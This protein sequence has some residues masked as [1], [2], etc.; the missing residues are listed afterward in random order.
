[1]ADQHEQTTAH[2][3]DARVAYL[4]GWTLTGAPLTDR[5]GPGCDVAVQLACEHAHD[6][7]I[8]EATL[9]LGSLE[10]TWA[11]V[12]DRRQQ[13]YD[14]HLPVVVDAWRTLMANLDVEPA[15]RSVMRRAGAV[16]HHPAA[17]AVVEAHDAEKDERRANAIAAMLDL[18]QTAFDG[19][20]GDVTALRTALAE[21]LRLADAEG[22]AGAIAIASEQIGI[23]AI[24]WGIAFKDGID[25][26]GQLE[27]YWGLA[28]D[29]ISKIVG[30]S[31]NDLGRALAGMVEDGE[32]IDVILQ[33]VSDI[34][35][36]T[37][38][39]AVR[40]LVD[41]AMSQSYSRGA[42]ALYTRQGA[43]T[44]DF[45]TAGDQRVCPVCTRIENDGPYPLLES[46]VPAMHP[47]CRCTLSPHD[48]LEA[49]GLSRY[50][51]DLGGE[52]TT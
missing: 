27:N 13:L 25:Q 19:H 22:W 45:L 34:L 20:H 30:S 4:T 32:P 10:G 18:L 35:T 6:P 5:T 50:A 33:A 12:Y 40:L 1:M 43:K 46:P 14:E 17:A 15:V 8:L 29:W 49:L 11:Q 26:L 38:M 48:P 47:W 7:D 3:H 44:V 9:L 42:L 31:A 16:E 41:M 37:D 21:A 23:V 52:G 28:D 39:D 2:A 36:G 24:D 51:A